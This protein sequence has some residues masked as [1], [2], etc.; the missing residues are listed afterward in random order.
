MKILKYL[1]FI[2]LGLFSG[3][4]LYRLFSKDEFAK[5]DYMIMV[6]LN[7]S[8]LIVTIRYHFHRLKE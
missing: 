5:I 4:L 8:G 2:V 6:V 7:L 1:F 3:Y